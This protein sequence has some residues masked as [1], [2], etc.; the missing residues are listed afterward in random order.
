MLGD[1]MDLAHDRCKMW[2]YA[3]VF[4][5]RSPPPPVIKVIFWDITWVGF[6][7][8]THPM[9]IGPVRADFFLLLELQL[10]HLV[11]IKDVQPHPHCQHINETSYPTF[12]CNPQLHDHMDCVRRSK[13]I[14]STTNLFRLKPLTSFPKC[15]SITLFCHLLFNC[16]NE[17]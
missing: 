11:V 14:L 5:I 12:L 15:F 13:F 2:S 7:V 3:R 1:L 17:C 16:D 6:K 8:R 10:V 9:R 4:G